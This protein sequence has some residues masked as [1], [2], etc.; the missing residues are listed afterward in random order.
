MQDV[1]ANLFTR[2]DTFFGVCQGLGEDLG[3]NSNWLR[4]AIPVPLFFYPL[5]T[6][7]GYLAAGLLVLALRLIFPVPLRAAAG[8]AETLPAREPALDSGS[9]VEAEKVPLAA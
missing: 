1:Q 8:E 7:A 6:I 5:E 3:I 9:E 2:D 4:M